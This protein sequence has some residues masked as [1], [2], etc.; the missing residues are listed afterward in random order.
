MP[1][2]KEAHAPQLLSPY[3]LESV[4]H[5]KRSHRILSN[6]RKPA[7]HNEAP[8]QPKKKKQNKTTDSEKKVRLAAMYFRILKCS[9]ELLKIA[10]YANL[11]A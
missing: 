10:T 6:W 9:K 5:H 11:K 8:G 1:L 3:T 7:H 4:F 2:G